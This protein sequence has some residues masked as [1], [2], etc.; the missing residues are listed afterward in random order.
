MLVKS[1]TWIVSIPL[2]I[3]AQQVGTGVSAREQLSPRQ[4]E[5]CVGAKAA[6]TRRATAAIDSNTVR[7][8]QRLGFCD[9]TAGTVLP[10]V[11]RS[12]GF[13]GGSP[14]ELE[15]LMVA[16][17][18][19]RDQRILAVAEEAAS[20]AAK[21]SVVRQAAIVVVA[22][23]VKPTLVGSLT[24]S[25]R[26]GEPWEVSVGLLDHVLQMPGSQPTESG[27]RERASRLLRSIADGNRG[28]LADL[29]NRLL[30][31]LQG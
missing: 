16:S 27:T 10:I 18:R 19:I 4:H 5:E 15:A 12:V 17:S 3:S 2:T 13:S 21:P 28:K 26:R 9:E 22:S 1:L 14:D 7:A 25:P 29:A 24:R 30:A 23:Y 20:D 8:I 6:V 11:W 31:D